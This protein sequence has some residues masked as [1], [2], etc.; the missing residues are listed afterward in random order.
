MYHQSRRWERAFGP[1]VAILG[2]VVLEVLVYLLPSLDTRMSVAA[3]GGIVTVFFLLIC[4]TRLEWGLAALLLL[5]ISFAKI[6]LYT[7]E[8]AG[9]Y[10]SELLVPFFLAVYL[11]RVLTRRQGPTEDS[12]IIRPL[13]LLSALAISSLLY[14]NLMWDRTVPTNHRYFI[15]QV[16]G[17]VLIILPVS[18]FILFANGF[19]VRKH[20]RR[21]FQLSVA[22]PSLAAVVVVLAFAA[23]SRDQLVAYALYG[24]RG[25][26]DTTPV[27]ASPFTS[28]STLGFLAIP[29][30]FSASV[31]TTRLRTRVVMWAFLAPPLVLTLASLKIGGLIATFSSLAVVAWFRSKR[32]FAALLIIAAILAVGETVVTDG[33][34]VAALI[35]NA[36]KKQS[37]DR[38]GIFKD[39]LTIWLTNPVLGVGPG[40]YYSYS[41][42]YS[43][44]L[45]VI[46]GNSRLAGE[47]SNPY[48]NAHNGYIQILSELG[49]VGFGLFLWFLVAALRRAAS[50]VRGAETLLEK[51]FATGAL[52]AVAGMLIDMF[53]MHGVYYSVSAE[54]YSTFVAGMYV[55]AALGML[56]ALSRR[57]SAQ[58]PGRAEGLDRSSQSEPKQYWANGARCVAIPA[59]EAGLRRRSTHGNLSI[60]ER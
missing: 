11:L 58:N 8:F 1:L 37:F 36:E 34:T 22:L 33:G 52:G 48:G 14:G 50:A 39:G 19:D 3:L 12:A 53:T 40:N 30:A 32:L 29:L 13:L 41:Y 25:I 7:Q 23:S 42:R 46:A 24:W 38:L 9:I 49:I 44:F 15:V 18:T 57:Q 43:S 17:V 27:W 16:V 26:V 2:I 21:L 20:L 31:Y 59:P 10:L 56:V 35:G 47:Q 6:P 28:W 54:G 45:N 51:A 55:W 5:G 4:L 60:Y